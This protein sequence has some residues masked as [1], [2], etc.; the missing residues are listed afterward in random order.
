MS[1]MI[2][3]IVSDS[4]VFVICIEPD[5]DTIN[6]RNVAIGRMIYIQRL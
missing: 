5:E 1:G 6:W 3:M 4:L 2:L